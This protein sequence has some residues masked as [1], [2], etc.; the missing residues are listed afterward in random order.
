MMCGSATSG[1]RPG[2]GWPAFKPGRGHRGRI[3]SN[4]KRISGK[5]LRQCQAL[6]IPEASA[7][8]GQARPAAVAASRL[9]ENGGSRVLPLAAGQKP[10]ALFVLRKLLAHPLD[11]LM[12]V[13][14]VAREIQI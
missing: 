11:E 7:S 12:D 8:P 9:S 6:P 10:T 2:S 1:W 5:T 13:V 14:L 4:K 3:I